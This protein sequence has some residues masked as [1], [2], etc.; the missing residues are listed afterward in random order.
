M[1]K[2]QEKL[3]RKKLVFD[4]SHENN[5]GN[6][7]NNKERKGKEMY[8]CRKPWHFK[9]ECWFLKSKNKERRIQL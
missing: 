4:K 2:T 6:Q 8:H 9:N 7:N 3:Q 1:K 5:N